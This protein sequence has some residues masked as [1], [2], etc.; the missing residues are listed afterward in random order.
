[1]SFASAVAIYAG[2]IRG[3]VLDTTG[4][5][6]PDATVRVLAARD[7][8]FV[9]GA[10]ANANGVYSITDIKAG[11]YIVQAN[12]IGFDPAYKNVTVKADGSTQV[13]PFKLTESSIMLKETTVVG[14]KT[15]IKVMEDT[16]EYNADT[17]KT[18]PNAV[19]E[20]LL[21]RLPG[22]EVG[23]D[24]SITANGQ[25]VKKILVDGKEFFSDDPAVA[26]KNLPVDMVDKLQVVQRKSDLARMTGVD[27]GED[28]TV[29]NLTVKKGMNNGWFGTVEG[30]YGTDERY[31]GAFVVNRFW[32]G[33]QL[34][35][36]GNANNMNDA[37][38]TDGNG[39]RF[40]RFGGNN[41]I[42]TTQSL[43]VNFNIGKEEIIRIGGDVMYSHNDRDTRT[44]QHVENLLTDMTTIEDKST[45]ARDKGHNVRGDFRVMWNVDSFNLVE[46]RQKWSLYFKDSETLGTSSNYNSLS[47]KI[48]N[49]RNL[50]DTHG[51]S[52]EFGG[53]LI[54][55][56]KFRNHKGRSVSFFGNY[57]LSNVRETEYSWSRNA[58]WQLDSLY[59]DY[60]ETTDHR[61]TNSVTG[62]VSWTEPL[63][64]P[65]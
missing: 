63:G 25:T 41:G 47:Q 2:T 30:G 28:E 5:P 34:T 45:L 22:V 60:Q 1:M 48:S 4:E 32:N 52:Y 3:K 39:N 38:F 54:Y 13:E 29:I 35:V 7:S 21:K 46:F 33:N 58:F 37:G 62:R 64:T 56:H 17:Y 18:Q 16:I 6:L 59:E 19:V 42:N 15:P 50:T 10:A 8:A 43:G 65:E 44:K 40:R 49:A 27:D 9:T 20:D 24:G 53:R 14:V 26:S 51:K 23:T 61:W 36:L 31:K 57:Q 55:N 11:K 12:Y